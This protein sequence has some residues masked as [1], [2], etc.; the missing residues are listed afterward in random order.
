MPV[1]PRPSD[2]KRKDELEK[3]YHALRDKVQVE[4]TGPILAR[5]G[6]VCVELQRMQEAVSFYN[7]ALQA[8]IPGAAY[9]ATRIK[10]KLTPDEVRATRHSGADNPD[11][12]GN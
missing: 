7:R 11:Q 6:D 12:R 8:D 10:N 9:L 1:P 5:L 4:A 3:E 2:D